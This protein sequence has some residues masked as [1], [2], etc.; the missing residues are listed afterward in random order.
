[1]YDFLRFT[2]WMAIVQRQRWQISIRGVSVITVYLSS[3]SMVFLLSH[4][5][6]VKSKVDPRLLNRVAY[7]FPEQYG[8]E[9]FNPL[10]HRIKPYATCEDVLNSKDL[11]GK[12]AIVTGANSGLGIKHHVFVKL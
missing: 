10:Y 11:T 6:G 2:I 9:S 7:D 12:V 3:L 8:I 5:E 1:M 4:I